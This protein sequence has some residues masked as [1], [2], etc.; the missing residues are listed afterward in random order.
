V[1]AVDLS[2][3]DIQRW[4]SDLSISP[5]R[6]GPP[7]FAPLRGGTGFQQNWIPAFAPEIEQNR[8]S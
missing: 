4:A 8:D 5:E 7:R 3:N 6:N 1:K 2:Y